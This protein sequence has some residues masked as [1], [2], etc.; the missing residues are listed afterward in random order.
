[1]SRRRTQHGVGEEDDTRTLL[2]GRLRRSQRPLKSTLP[3]QRAVPWLIG[4]LLAVKQGDAET[5]IIKAMR[6]MPTSVLRAVCG[7][8]SCGCCSVSDLGI[9]GVRLQEKRRSQATFRKINGSGQNEYF[10]ET[11]RQRPP[12]PSA[13]RHEVPYSAAGGQV[14]ER[15]GDEPSPTTPGRS[16][17]LAA[18]SRPGRGFT[19]TLGDGLRGW[20][21]FTGFPA[22][23]VGGWL[24]WPTQAPLGPG[25]REGSATG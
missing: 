10:D 24:F 6:S 8:P 5:P 25:I 20:V 2:L 15:V 7:P 13:V 18:D 14:G 23:A 16:M 17:R 4:C 9:C 19:V 3:T 12:A 21:C 22:G 11:L 1:M